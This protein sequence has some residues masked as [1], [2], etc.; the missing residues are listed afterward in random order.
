MDS[1]DFGIEVYEESSMHHYRTE[2]PNIIFKMGL[3]P[4]EIAGYY[5]LK[6]TAGDKGCC[7]KSNETICQ[8]LM[9]H[10]TK[11]KEVKKSLQLK[12]LIK[13]Q[14]KRHRNGGTIQDVITI[15]YIWHVNINP[16]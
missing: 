2:L 13:I 4:Y 15:V 10:N 7:F 9:C 1:K 12:G 5:I 11:W 3:N 6:M 16:M 8:E 14:K